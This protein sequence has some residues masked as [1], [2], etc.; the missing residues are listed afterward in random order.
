MILIMK[1]HIYRG[2]SYVLFDRVDILYRSRKLDQ[3]I[4]YPFAFIFFLQLDQKS[5]SGFAQFGKKKH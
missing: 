3:I 1:K 2:F 5:T 4:L